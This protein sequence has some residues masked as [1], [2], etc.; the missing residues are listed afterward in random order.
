MQEKKYRVNLTEKQRKELINLTRRGKSSARELT[1]ARVLLLSDENRPNRPM[2]DSQIS[3]IFS[4][5]LYRCCQD[6]QCEK[7]TITNAMVSA[8]SLSLLNH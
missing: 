5:S 1:R 4:V 3:E 8:L 7:I 6:S 2:T